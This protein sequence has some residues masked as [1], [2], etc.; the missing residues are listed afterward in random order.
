[1]NT[2]AR[3]PSHFAKAG[4]GAGQSTA[5]EASIDDL[6]VRSTA[7]FNRRMDAL[8][9]LL[10]SSLRFQLIGLISLVGTLLIGFAGVIY[11]LL[12]RSHTFE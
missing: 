10:T 5:M 2:E 6:L 3:T 12:M 4:S 8:E 11:A 9:K 7:N 1:M